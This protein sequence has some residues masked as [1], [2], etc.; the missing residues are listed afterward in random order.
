MAIKLGELLIE[1]GV[2]DRTQLSQALQHQRTHGGRLGTNLVELGILDEKTL[3]G[4]LAKQMSIPSATAAQLDRVDAAALRLLRPETAERLRAVPLREDAGRLWVAMAD[5]TDQMALKELERLVGKPVRAMVAPELLIQYAL[6]KHYGVRRKARVMMVRE[7]S[8]LLDFDGHRAPRVAMP[9]QSPAKKGPPPPPGTQP[10]TNEAPVWNWYG[11]ESPQGQ[12]VASLSGFLDEQIKP[13]APKRERP[14]L[15]IVAEKLLMAD[16]DE[17]IFDVALS[18]V[19]IDAEKL[20]AF[21]L[22]NGQLVGWRGR[23]VDDAQLK[24]VKIKLEDAPMLAG[25]LASGQAWVGSVQ[26]K[27]L[28]ALAKPLGVFDEGL[29]VVLPVRIGKR[30]VAAVV[31]LQASDDI[32]RHASTINKLANKIDQALHIG[33]LRRQILSD[34]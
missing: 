29:G 1:A 23:G 20:A 25:V 9:P 31:G 21:L 18:Y 32:M 19:G 33:Y 24:K 10:A 17:A 16:S 14:P 12:A 28:G 26:L 22:R 13:E 15:K 4:V 8:G 34:E 5:P 7:G 3:A 11:S 30:A 2:I 6:E 27:D